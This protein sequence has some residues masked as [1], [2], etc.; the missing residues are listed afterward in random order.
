MIEY[1]KGEIQ[2]LTPTNVVLETQ[3]LGYFINITL[4]TYADIQA[5]RSCK[6][7]IYEAIRE[8]AHNLYGFSKMAERVI[9]MHLLSV[10]GVGANTARLI[11]SSLTVS[12]LESCILSENTAVLMA[13]KGIGQ[14]TVQRILVDLKDKIAKSA[15]DSAKT[16]ASGVSNAEVREEAVAALLMLGFNQ[17][18]SLKVVNKILL[19]LP[20]VPVEQVV[21]MALKLL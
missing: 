13:V 4:N 2:T 12:E 14:K 15:G 7:Y 8:D 21:K 9:F 19:D 3:G 6:L 10:S 18:Q 5:S 17:S 20:Q 16:V 1:I 11:L